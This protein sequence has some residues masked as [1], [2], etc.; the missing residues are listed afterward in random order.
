MS[1]GHGVSEAQGEDGSQPLADGGDGYQPLAD[2]EESLEAMGGTGIELLH[3]S[4]TPLTM[5]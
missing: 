4:V 2:G 1:Q 3:N 5:E